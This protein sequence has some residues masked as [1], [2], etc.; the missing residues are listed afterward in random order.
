MD[1][2][3]DS[4]DLADIPAWISYTCMEV[5]REEEALRDV[6][7]STDPSGLG[8]LGAVVAKQSQLWIN[9]QVIYFHALSS[10]RCNQPFDL[11]L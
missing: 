2:R 9:G 3:D 8:G 7:A 1:H 6:L 10:K 4:A 11:R 5:S